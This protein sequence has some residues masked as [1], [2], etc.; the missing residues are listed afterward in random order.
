MASLALMILLGLAGLTA[1]GAIA[2]VVALVVR[3][4]KV[5]FEERPRLAPTPD[6]D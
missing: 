3:T 1:L 6:E 2:L 5:T 4:G